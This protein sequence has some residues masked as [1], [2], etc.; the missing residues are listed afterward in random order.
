MLVPETIPQFGI[1]A[2]VMLLVEPAAAEP[3]NITCGRAIHAALPAVFGDVGYVPDSQIVPISV[4][5]TIA[6]LLAYGASCCPYHNRQH[7]VYEFWELHTVHHS[8][9]A[10]AGTRHRTH[11]IANVINQVC[12]GL[13]IGREYGFWLFFALDPVETTILGIKAYVLRNVVM[14]DFLKPSRFEI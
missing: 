8:A 5:F 14:L 13:A 9:E 10:M 7:R 12:G 3:I 4:L 11:R 1:A 2:N 6:A